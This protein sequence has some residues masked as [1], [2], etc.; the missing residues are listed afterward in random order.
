MSDYVDALNAFRGD[1][2]HAAVVAVP[3][4]ITTKQTRKNTMKRK[5]TPAQLRALKKGRAALKKKRA[6]WQGKRVACILTGGNASL[7]NRK[8]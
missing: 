5:A 1:T 6:Q 3:R 7:P 8:T 4:K 2:K